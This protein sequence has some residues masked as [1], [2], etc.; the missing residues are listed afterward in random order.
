MSKKE[1]AIEM[2]KVHEDSIK[3]ATASKWLDYNKMMYT[4]GA[5]NRI[6]VE[7]AERL[8]NGLW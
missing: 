6:D 4:L 7:R 2:K 3:R 1:M 5:K 8:Y